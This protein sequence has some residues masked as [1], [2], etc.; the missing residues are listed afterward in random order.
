VDHHSNHQASHLV[1]VLMPDSL[2]VVVMVDHHHTNHQASHL[3][4]VL[5]VDMVLVLDSVV[6]LML[7]SLLLIPTKMVHSIVTNLA[8]SLVKTLVVVVVVHHSNHHPSA[9]NPIKHQNNPS[10]I[11]YQI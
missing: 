1:V 8:P 11:D 6:V 2:L 9:Q 4:V 10:N 7:L 3:V 5:V